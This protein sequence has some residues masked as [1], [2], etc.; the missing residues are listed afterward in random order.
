M[1]MRE[2]WRLFLLGLKRRKKEVRRLKV[3][4]CL[5]VFFITFMLLFQDNMNSCQME[6]NYRSF[7]TWLTAAPDEATFGSFS[8]LAETGQI[9]RGSFLYTQPEPDEI[10]DKLLASYSRGALNG[11]RIGSFTAEFAQ[12]NRISLYSG[13]LP[14]KPGEIAMELATLEALGKS[15]ELGQEITFCLARTYDPDTLQ[16]EAL[17]RKYLE[18]FLASQEGGISI[19]IG[20]DMP[21]QEIT[22]TEADWMV[23]LYPV[24][25]TLVGTID[26][27]S[28]RWSVPD[29]PNAI[30]CREEFDSL[31]MSR[32]TVRFYNF[33]TSLPEERIW[34]TSLR[35]LNELIAETSNSEDGSGLYPMTPEA[36]ERMSTNLKAFNNPFWG[37]PTM[38]RTMTVLLI[39]LGSCIVAYLMASYLNKR[40]PFFLRMR[41]IGATAGEVWRMAAYECTLSTVPAAL[42]TLVIS[43]G[44]AL[45]T[46]LAVS[47]MVKIP[48][49]F[50]FSFRTLGVILLSLTATLAISLLAALIIFAGRGITEKQKSLGKAAEKS[51][52]RRSLRRQKRARPYLGF[53]ETLRRRRITNQLSGIFMSLVGIAV[54]VVLLV[55]ATNIYQKGRA[56]IRLRNQGSFI[57]T[58]QGN[59][60]S[61]ATRIPITKRPPNW[62]KGLAPTEASTHRWNNYSLD[63]M[64]PFEQLEKLSSL[65]GVAHL[66]RYTVDST[67][68]VRWEGKD[69][70]PF[71][72]LYGSLLLGAD[73][74]GHENVDY[75][76]TDAMRTILSSH[77]RRTLYQIVTRS[78]PEVYWKEYSSYLDP[79]AADYEAFLR[80]EQVILAVDKSLTS[81][82]LKGRVFIEDGEKKSN[83]QQYIIGD[84]G[85]TLFEYEEGFDYWD[86]LGHT[87][88]PGSVLEIEYKGGTIPVTVAGI[89]PS[90]SV[91]F[92]F[93]IR[94]I[95]ESNY[96]F[97]L[98]GSD[99]ITAKLAEAEGLTPGSN[100]FSV[101]FNDMLERENTVDELVKLCTQY[102]AKYQS[103]VQIL[104]ERQEEFLQAALIYGFVALVLVILF[105]FVRS[106][107]AAEERFRLQRSAFEYHRS[108]VTRRQLGRDKTIDAL[109]GSLHLLLAIPAYYGYMY[110]LKYLETLAEYYPQQSNPN[111]IVV[112]MATMWSDFFKMTVVS[113]K[114]SPY[115][116]ALA[117]FMDSIAPHLILPI[118]LL[119]FFILWRID[120]RLPSL[121]APERLYRQE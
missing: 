61:Y 51:I 116:F 40:R 8:E 81:S 35:Y 68:K 24:T 4:M 37:N 26:R 19:N 33:S 47:L 100:Y 34:D 72:A 98:L 14:E 102:G 42:V 49:F 65:P 11:R 23:E 60:G 38:Y 118:I 29:L 111:L 27:Y 1:T 56:Y 62:P 83:Y 55:S 63:Y 103:S 119:L 104:R 9:Q 43:Y 86:S 3:M 89:V 76:K 21:E 22:A 121:E 7:G 12:R 30:V 73:I 50:V 87:I 48:Y 66:E 36:A 114:V 31:Q 57:G 109:L 6:L 10:T 32:D 70:D 117:I 88:K 96:M 113:T 120:S 91:P 108:G 80:G 2:G 115:F 105:V 85:T 99:A 44:A 67:H 58:I 112:S 79:A 54:A 95:W 39:L 18:R 25:F 28:S 110:Y 92:N 77:E 75:T 106:C 107:M 5:A 97:A 59:A 82:L 13:R 78:T 71:W 16:R 20:T 93:N 84:E 52:L 46:V 17:N 41:T 64:L 90:Q 69:Q 101:T 74:G 45:L 15:Y 94:Y 53:R